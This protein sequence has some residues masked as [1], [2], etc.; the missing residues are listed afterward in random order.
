MASTIAKMTPDYRL[1]VLSE[2]PTEPVNG[3]LADNLAQKIVDSYITELKPAA[4]N[5][6]KQRLLLREFEIYITDDEFINDNMNDKN[7]TDYKKRSINGIIIG[8]H[9]IGN[10]RGE[11]SD[12][13]VNL[14]VIYDSDAVSYGAPK[15]KTIY[16]GERTKEAYIGDVRRIVDG[17]EISFDNKNKFGIKA[18]NPKKNVRDRKIEK[19]LEKLRSPEAN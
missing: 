8:S 3:L 1:I 13:I 19:F 4:E 12:T 5:I 11:I 17:M 14:T 2:L 10:I 16:K 9:G 7:S 15:G 6:I 18:Y